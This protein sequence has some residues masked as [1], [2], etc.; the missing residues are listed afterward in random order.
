MKEN[1]TRKGSARSVAASTL[2]GA[3]KTTKA[4]AG[5]ALQDDRRE[6]VGRALSDASDKVPLF[7]K[8]VK[9]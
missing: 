5:R 8:T 6:R 4:V 2:A 7:K 3:K 1:Y 9:S